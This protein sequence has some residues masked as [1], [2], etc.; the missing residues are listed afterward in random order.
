MISLFSITLVYAQFPINIG[1][2]NVDWFGQSTISPDNNLVIVGTTNYTGNWSNGDVNLRK[3]D[4]NGNLI[5]NKVYGSGG[6]EDVASGVISTSDGGY[7]IFAGHTKTY[8]GAAYTGGVD[9]F[10]ASYI[11][12]VDANGNQLW[13]KSL[14]GASYGDN[15]GV[16][17]VENSSGEYVCY[18]HVQ[19]HAGCSSYATRILKLS[20]SGNIIWSNCL[21]VNPDVVSGFAKIQGENNYI[22][23]HNLGGSVVLRKY[24]DNGIVTNQFNYQYQGTAT[25]SAKLV[26]NTNGEF[27]LLGSSNN[28]AVVA[29]FDN[30]FNLL[31]DTTFATTY[32][33]RFNDLKL[34]GSNLILVGDVEVVDATNEYDFWLVKLTSS[35]QFLSQYIDPTPGIDV[36]ARGSSIYQDDIYVTGHISTQGINQYATKINLTQT[37]CTNT[38]SQLSITSCDSYTAPNGQTYTAGGNYSAIVPNANG[39]DSI[40]AI[41]LTI[42]NSSSNSFEVSSCESYTAPDGQEYS[43]SGLYTAI[44]P[45]SVGCDS[46]ITIDLTINQPTTSSISEHSCGDYIAPDGQVFSTSGVYSSVISNANGCDSTITIDLSVT[47]IDNSVAIDELLLSSNQL[48][49]AYQWIDCENNNQEIFGQFNQNFEATQNG[50]YAVEIT[51]EGCIDTS[52]C[53]LV[54]NVGLSSFDQENF[55][56]YVN[57]IDETLVLFYEGMNEAVSLNIIDLNGKLIKTCPIHPVIDLAEVNSGLYFLQLIR[58]DGLLYNQKFIK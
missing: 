9:L 21:Q 7:I 49:A 25:T 14:G 37:L 35:G 44:I 18:G 47:N 2:S 53:I 50:Q 13:A 27:Y 58:S 51:F 16:T 31:W 36:L 41:N 8:S 24:N 38:S 1:T 22:G 5:W 17:L 4:L 3:V 19:N 6:A 30:A 54:N 55:S 11:I 20:S 33:S 28:K 10:S 57:S 34:Y 56:F 23:A 29:K 15:Y 26:S 46:T 32:N 39:C 45:N 48:V 43:A 12:K 40:I 42:N 52:D